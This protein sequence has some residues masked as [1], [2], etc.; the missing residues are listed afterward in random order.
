MSASISLKEKAILATL[1]V[2]FLYGALAVF[3]FLFQEKA[4][5]RASLDYE[6]KVEKYNREVKLI[7]QK[8][9]YAAEYDEEKSRMPMFSIEAHNTDTTWLRKMD[10]F[11]AKYNVIIAQTD[12]GPE[13]A[14]GDVLERTI[15]VRNFEGSLEA[16]VKFMYELENSEIGMFDMKSLNL[17]PSQKKG[18]LKGSF[19]ITCAYM[20]TDEQEEVEVDFK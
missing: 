11:A 17:K 14:A 1:L 18:Y 5:R 16:L 10:D 9:K 2:I 15:T 19:T 12:I 8:S 6:K 4:W 3:W 7:S 13:E 20:R